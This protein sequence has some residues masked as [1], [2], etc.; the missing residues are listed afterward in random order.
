MTANGFVQPWPHKT[1][2]MHYFWAHKCHSQNGISIS[3]A[4]FAIAAKAL[5]S[6]KWHGQCTK[7]PLLFG[8]LQPHPTYFPSAHPT[9]ST[10]TGLTNISDRPT[11]RQTDHVTPCVAI[12]HCHCAQ[13]KNSFHNGIQSDSKVIRWETAEINKNDKQLSTKLASYQNQNTITRGRTDHFSTTL[14]H[15]P[16]D[17]CNKAHFCQSLISFTRGRQPRMHSLCTLR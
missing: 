14:S 4:I 15:C 1:H 9:W 11:D 8:D 13:P 6:F 17:N 7:S 16:C 3:S 2:K 5:N 10:F 12:G